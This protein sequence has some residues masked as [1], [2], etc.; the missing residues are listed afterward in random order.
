[1]QMKFTKVYY[2]VDSEESRNFRFSTK[3]I[4]FTPNVTHLHVST[5]GEGK[6]KDEI[7]DELNVNISEAFA[8]KIKHTGELEHT[9]MSVGDVLLEF[10]GWDEKVFVCDSNGWNQLSKLNAHFKDVWK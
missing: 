1:M 2:Q 6:S 3:G 7:F 5:F 8:N 10:D 9:S 4:T